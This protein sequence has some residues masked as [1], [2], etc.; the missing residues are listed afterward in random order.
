MIPI[1]EYDPTD[2]EDEEEFE[3]ESEP[4]LTYKLD[5]E[6]KLVQTVLIDEK[7]ALKQAIYKI[8]QTERYAYNMYD[9]DYGVEMADYIGQDIDE[10]LPDIQNAI[11]D[12][13]TADDRIESVDYIEVEREKGKLYI[14]MQ[15]NTIY[16]DLEVETVV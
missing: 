5:L 9:W 12:A 13:L 4:S 16:G 10:V 15:I 6:N 1:E 3:I 11:E 2:Y 7:E 14:S 8:L